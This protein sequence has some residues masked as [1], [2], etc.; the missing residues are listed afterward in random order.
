MSRNLLPQIARQ[1]SYQP[2]NWTSRHRN[3][4]GLELAGY[5]N[6]E[7]ATILD[8]S[9]GKVSVTLQDDRAAIDRLEMAGRIADKISDVHLSLQ[10]LSH[11]AIKEAAEVMRF[12]EK[13]EV[14]LKAA[15]GILDRAGY[16]TVHKTEDVNKEAMPHEVLDRMSEVLKEMNEHSQPY[17]TPS[18]VFEHEEE[19]EV[20][21]A[22]YEVVA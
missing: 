11:E 8:W 6:N 7:I 15:F 5:K 2:V 9:E 4:V 1:K 12:T 10:L 17:A 14:K 13:D 22:D 19:E 20:Q 16:S 21:E 18:P 3:C